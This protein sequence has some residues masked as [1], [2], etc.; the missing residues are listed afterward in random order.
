MKTLKLLEDV[1]KLLANG[2]KDVKFDSKE[3]RALS[4]INANIEWHKKALR[5]NLD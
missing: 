5:N 3:F 1:K 4:A 2:C